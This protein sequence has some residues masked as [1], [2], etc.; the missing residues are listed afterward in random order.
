MSLELI[1]PKT[2]RQ[3]F[4][5]DHAVES[6]EGVRRVLHKPELCGPMIRGGV[7]SRTPPLWNPEKGVWEWWYM[8]ADRHATSADGESWQVSSGL[9]DGLATMP[10]LYHIVRDEAEPNPAR[11]YKGLFGSTGRQLGVSADGFDW[12]M[13]DVVIP[14]QDESQFTHD[15]EQDRFLGFVKQPTE[16]G[17]SVWM[18]TSD[19]FRQ[20]SEPELI[21]HADEVDWEN[22]RQRVKRIVEDPA[23][24]TPPI[25]DDVD[26]RAEIYNMAVL[27]YQGLYIGFPTVFNPIGAIP[28]PATNYTRINQIELAVSHDLRHWERVANREVFIGVEPWTGDNYG[29]SQLLP[30][31]APVVRDDGEIW[32]YYNALRMP[33]SRQQYQEF[34]RSKELFR[35]GVSAEAWQDLGAL[36]LA[37]LPA[38]RFAALEAD[39]AGQVLTKP[40]ELKGE[41]VY[42]NADAK[43]GKVYVEIVEG[44]SRKAVE[45][46]WVPL[47]EP[48]PFVGDEVRFKVT[49]KAQ[50]DLV[51]HQP[52]RLR[53]YL[54]QARLYSFWIE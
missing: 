42:L 36:S 22:C 23:Y 31:G 34:N 28:P 52:V 40:F 26:Y 12:D 35:L 29:T 45:G 1:D 6:K 4:L 20:F 11:R 47:E 30:S 13:T 5:D 3:L 25:V 16:W 32:C 7:Q 24:I 38:D 8:G 14:S 50:H 53:F 51:F 44:A 37:K 19:D 10:T 21:L 27:P 18:S 43:W 9:A 39:E 17:R 15:V 54:H 33:G 48:E 2:H 41:D 49:W 46:F